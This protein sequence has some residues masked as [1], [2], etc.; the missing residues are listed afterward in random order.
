VGQPLHAFDWQRLGSNTI[1]VRR[2]HPGER[3]RT[4]DGE[5]RTLS[6]SMMVVTDGQRA[7][8]LA[9]IMGGEDSEIADTTREV[10]L[11]GASWDR[12]TTRR[13]SAALTLSTEASR[14]FGRGV[15]PD[16]TTLGVAR[17]TELTLQL[18]G[19]GAAAGMADEYPG[20]T[21]LA[22][23]QFRPEQVDRLLGMSI[24]R[25][26][27]IQT[28][29]RL[30]FEPRES[31]GMPDS[32]RV[33]VPGW[34]RFDVEGPADIAEEIGRI[35]GFNLVPTTIPDG[36]LP[37]PRPDGDGGYSVEL[38]ARRLL[39]AAGLQEVITYS[40]VDPAMAAQFVAQP[41]SE[42]LAS[43]LIIANPQSIELSQL[44]P[45]LFGSLLLTLR[46]NLRQRDRVLLFE[47]AR[48]WEGSMDPSPEERRHVGIAMVG[49]RNPRH[50]ASPEGNLDFFDTKGIVDALCAAFHVP[51]SFAP[52][53]HPSLHP[54]R[55]SEICIDAQRLG[56]I[57]QVHPA[58]AE[59][60]DLTAAPVLYAELDF[61]RL[62]SAARPVET[63]QTPS[64]F[65]PADRDISFFIDETTPHADLE[66]AIREA[67]G[68]L[69]ERVE[70]FDVF[71][72]GSVPAGRQSLAFSLRYRAMDR[73]LEDDEVSVAHGRVEQTLKDRFGAEVR[74][75]S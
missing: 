38:R 4:L 58:V 74:G 22:T 71:H 62:V 48:I 41:T 23:I 28:L 3:L 15:D 42:P 44:R 27:A 24:P 29:E 31:D 46:G 30:G 13:T 66:T 12:A 5:E 10:I 25:A 49:P 72:G 33:T 75:R 40:L 43:P 8:S 34:R 69:L 1:V 9:G 59:R 61:D 21:S 57:G 50:W 47:L 16:L 17:A 7:R 53:K 68:E 51:V 35:A 60:F 32:V 39:A 70:L 56:V 52:A 55:S 18:A 73:T 11:E 2:A 36:A 14:R 65:P 26:D 6:E 19:G 37:A 20:K 64:R 67:A 63:V 54:G 45:N